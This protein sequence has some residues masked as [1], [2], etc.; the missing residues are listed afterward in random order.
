VAMTLLFPLYAN[1]VI[2]EMLKGTITIETS[3][4]YGLEIS[5]FGEDESHISIR[6]D[7]REFRDCSI[8]RA[9]LVVKNRNDVAI[10]ATDLHLREGR[11]FF[12]LDKAYL[13][14]S[15]VGL[16]CELVESKGLINT[17]QVEFGELL[18]P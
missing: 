6:L 14:S 13:K 3:E 16:S 18:A 17:Y 12:R 15:Q 1:G 5:S 7:A 4:S 9:F 8:D 2:V 10:L 11:Y